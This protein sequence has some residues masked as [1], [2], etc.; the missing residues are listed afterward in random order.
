MLDFELRIYT[1]N[2]SFYRT[3]N[4]S[5]GEAE[6][7]LLYSVSNGCW[8]IP[9]LREMLEHILP[10]DKTIRGFEIEQDFPGVGHKVLVLSARK[11][12]DLQHVLVNIEDVNRDEGAR[13]SRNV[14]AEFKRRWN[15]SL[16]RAPA[17][18]LGF[19]SGRCARR[20]FFTSQHCW[21]CHLLHLPAGTGQRLGCVGRSYPEIWNRCMN[22]YL[23]ALSDASRVDLPEEHLQHGRHLRAQRMG[24]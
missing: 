11:L 10:D 6:G 3:F 21:N 4:I 13:R 16:T 9:G 15:H 24:A 1:A 19:R 20:T 18:D 23:S 12:D 14:C 22:T 7:R 2:A 5:Q 17:D 8:D